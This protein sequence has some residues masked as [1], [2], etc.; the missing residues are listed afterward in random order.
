MYKVTI[1]IDGMM[2]GMCESHICETIRNAFPGAKKV[3]ASRKLREAEF[4]TDNPIDNSKLEKVIK[5]TGYT[6]IS[7]QCEVYVKKGIFG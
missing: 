5:E 7:S 2:C 6:Y 1:K 4:I 3:K